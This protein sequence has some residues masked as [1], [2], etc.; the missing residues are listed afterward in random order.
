MSLSEN[1]VF[2]ALNQARTD[3]RSLI[4]YI[5]KTLDKFVDNMSYEII[6]HC[7]M[8]TREGKSAWMEAIAFLK[9]QQPL[10][11]LASHKGLQMAAQ[12]HANDLAAND[13]MGH[14]GSNKSSMTDRILLFCE[15][16]N[17]ELGENVAQ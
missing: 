10:S 9:Q 13:M 11:P 3:P 17:G 6:P 15:R 14:Y 2:E 16:D 4:P 7:N 8:V 12:L 5:T 1:K